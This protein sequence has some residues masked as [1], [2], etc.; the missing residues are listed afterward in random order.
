MVKRTCAQ[1]ANMHF[2]TVF[3]AAAGIVT[4]AAFTR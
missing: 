1:L 4:V 2:I 3:G